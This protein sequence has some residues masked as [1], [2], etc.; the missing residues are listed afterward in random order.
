MWGRISTETPAAQLE[1][2][3]VTEDIR[4]T[5]P[6]FSSILGTCTTV[7]KSQRQS[8]RTSVLQEGTNRGCKGPPEQVRFFLNGPG[9]ALDPRLGAVTPRTMEEDP[10]MM[11]KSTWAEGCGST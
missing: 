7:W 1:C 11:E 2:V 9:L 6:R 8:H 3:S 10:Y 4:P 5:L